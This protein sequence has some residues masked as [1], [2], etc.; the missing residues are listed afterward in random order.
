MC[1]CVG[2]GCVKQAP[3][4]LVQTVDVAMTTDKAVF[5]GE[6]GNFQIVESQSLAKS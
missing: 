6:G 4:R 5:Q 2:G 1:V 3:Y